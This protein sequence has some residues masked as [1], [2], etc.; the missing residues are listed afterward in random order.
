MRETLGEDADNTPQGAMPL[1]LREIVARI[2]AFRKPERIILFGSRARGDAHSAS[3]YDLLIIEES[4][5]PRYRRSAPLYTLLAD[6]PAEIEITVYTPQET[7]KWTG[8][9]G[10][11]VNNALRDGQVLY[12]GKN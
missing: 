3:D 10:S 7:M 12:D 6:L 9:E 5:E 1:L 2:T 4:H 11:L 8:V